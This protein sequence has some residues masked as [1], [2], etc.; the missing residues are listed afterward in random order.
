MYTLCIDL[1]DLSK[2]YLNP[3]GGVPEY[4]LGLSEGLNK[5]ETPLMFE[6]HKAGRGTIMFLPSSPMGFRKMFKLMSKHTHGQH[7]IPRY[8]KVYNI[9]NASKM[10]VFAIACLCAGFNFL[11][12]YI[13]R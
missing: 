5:D 4:V 1:F 11:I 10:S 7:H 12:Y 3:K 9:V 2:D 8:I 6:F 13:I